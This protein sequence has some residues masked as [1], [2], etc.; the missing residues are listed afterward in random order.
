MQDTNLAEPSFNAKITDREPEV[1]L[2]AA[3]FEPPPHRESPTTSAR[4]ATSPRPRPRRGSSCSRSC[5]RRYATPSPIR[6]ANARRF[7]CASRG[8]RPSA[9]SRMTEGGSTP[10]GPARRHWRARL[11]GRGDGARWRHLPGRLVRARGHAGRGGR[12]A[13]TKISPRFVTA[14]VAESTSRL[15]FHALR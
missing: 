10:G 7:G 5:A 15:Y 11:H 2:Q 4:K 3:L 9:W 14:N 6:G 8:W 13:T 12:T 1:T